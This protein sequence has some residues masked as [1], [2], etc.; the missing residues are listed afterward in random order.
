MLE[1]YFLDT[2]II[3]LYFEAVCEN[4]HY[5]M[6]KPQSCHKIDHKIIL[7]FITA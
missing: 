3:L 5:E 1:C 7:D 2:H 4:K 6:A